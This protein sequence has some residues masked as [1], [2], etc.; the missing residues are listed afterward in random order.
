VAQGLGRYAS[1]I[2]QNPQQLDQLN[3]RL[4]LIYRL[5]R[6]HGCNLAELIVEGERMR[7]ELQG[8]ESHDEEMAQLQRNL[9]KLK[10]ETNT[11]AGELSALRRAAAYDLGVKV[12]RRLGKLCMKG[13]R[14][15]VDVKPD[16]GEDAEEPV[17]LSGRLIGPHGW[18]RIEFLVSA[19]PGEA[20]RSLAR[21]ASGGELSRVMLALRQ[22]IGGLDPVSTSI[23]DEVDTGIGGAVADVVGQA[24]AE[25]AGFRQVLCVTHLPQV[26]AYADQHLVV[27]KGSKKGT[28]VRELDDKE[29]VEELA[30]MLGGR[31]VTKQARANAS[32]LIASALEKRLPA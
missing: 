23:Y 26:A 18:D 21:Y 7:E 25:V 28:V 32:E 24:L 14:F 4:E 19:N 31:K 6:K 16:L 5:T 20:P 8:L 17:D 12:S 10:D 9:S 2:D 15:V 29:R 22:V 11:K 3:E 30:R 27:G 1:G 13:A